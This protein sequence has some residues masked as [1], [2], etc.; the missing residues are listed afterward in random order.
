MLDTEPVEQ[1]QVEFQDTVIQEETKE[2]DPFV[3]QA[4]VDVFLIDSM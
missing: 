1:P 3:Q 2:L 4:I